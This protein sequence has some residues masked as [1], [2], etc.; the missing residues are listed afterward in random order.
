M[1]GGR[2]PTRKRVVHMCGGYAGSTTGKGKM[3]AQAS[4]AA[5]LMGAYMI[6]ELGMNT[7]QIMATFKRGKGTLF[8]PFLDAGR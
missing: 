2:D 1:A 6:F 5:V 7:E 8:Q 4:N 3:S